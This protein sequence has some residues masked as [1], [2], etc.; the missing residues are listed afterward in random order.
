M[1]ANYYNHRQILLVLVPSEVSEQLPCVQAP[2]GKCMQTGRHS[3]PALTSR[4]AT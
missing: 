3:E 2:K 1:L 4:W